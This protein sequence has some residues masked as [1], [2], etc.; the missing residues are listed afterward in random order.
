MSLDRSIQLCAFIKFPTQYEKHKETIRTC[1]CR[2]HYRNNK[3]CP[4]CGKEIKKVIVTRNRKIDICEDLLDDPDVF[5]DCSHKD[6]TYLFS[7]M[8]ASKSGIDTDEN[9]FVTITP[10]IIKGLV[11]G[12]ETQYAKEIVLLKEK[13]NIDIKVEF[14]FAHFCW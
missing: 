13:L 14:G 2:E 1:G 7:N 6:M 9:S 4:D 10:K 3:F 12:F 11:L 5:F 8:N